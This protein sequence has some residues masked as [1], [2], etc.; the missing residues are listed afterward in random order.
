MTHVKINN[1]PKLTLGNLLK[2]RKTKLKDFLKDLGLTSYPAL[3][4]Y[5]ETNGIEEPSETEFKKNSEL[6]TDP[7]EGII[8]LEAVSSL[9]EDDEPKVEKKRRRK[10]NMN[11]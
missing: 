11:D 6:V 9:Q 1:K 10:S 3:V 5:C 4:R 8:V 2:R 7:S